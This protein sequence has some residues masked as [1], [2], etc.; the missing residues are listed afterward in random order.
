MERHQVS[1]KFVSLCILILSFSSVR[2]VHG[3]PLN[4][5]LSKRL[6]A[7]ATPESGYHDV[8][9]PSTNPKTA[10][11]KRLD[12]GNTSFDP[13]IGVQGK[14]V[15]R[16]PVGVLQKDYPD[17]FNMLLLAMEAF[18]SEDEN[19]DLSYNRIAGE[20]SWRRLWILTHQQQESMGCLTP[21]S[22]LLRLLLLLAR[23]IAHI[24]R[25]SSEH[26]IALI[27]CCLR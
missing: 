25:C 9:Y 6:L 10:L 2:A 18:Q 5:Y 16:R 22:T 7:C 4:S 12:G 23:G 15:E 21:G 13:I 27:S 14:I 17:V 1:I 26:G 3:G 19:D 24:T 11:T 20:P 8:L